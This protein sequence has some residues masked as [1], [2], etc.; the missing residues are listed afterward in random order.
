M[1]SLQM[2]SV[3]APLTSACLAPELLEQVLTISCPH[4]WWPVK[5]WFLPVLEHYKLSLPWEDSEKVGVWVNV[6]AQGYEL[7]SMWLTFTLLIMPKYPSGGIFS[8]A[9]ICSFVLE[10]LAGIPLSQTKHIDICKMLLELCRRPDSSEV[11]SINGLHLRQ[12]NM[13]TN[14]KIYRCIYYEIP[15]EWWKWLNTWVN[16]YKNPNHDW[17]SV[18][19]IWSSKF[20][21]HAPLCRMF[22]SCTPS[23]DAETTP[24]NPHSVRASVPSYL[25]CLSTKFVTWRYTSCFVQEQNIYLQHYQHISSHPPSKCRGNGDM[26]A[27]EE[28]AQQHMCQGW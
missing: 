28:R 8:T 24:F 25:W 5:L 12:H 16:P 22:N 6:W 18:L 3:L 15:L 19:Y 17:L 13:D 20:H 26:A 14:Y 1:S 11:S 21:N 9:H 27:M 10:W 23:P 7:H 2:N 4:H